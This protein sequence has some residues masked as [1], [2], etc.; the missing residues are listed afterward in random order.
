MKEKLFCGSKKYYINSAITIVLMFGFRFLPPIGT[1]SQVGMGVL[2]VFLGAI[3]GW[4][5]VGIFW[6]SALSIIALSFTGYGKFSELISTGMGS[7]T[8]IVLVTMFGLLAI[9]NESG[10]SMYLAKKIIGLKIGRGRP[11]VVVYLLMTACSL[12]FGVTGAFPIALMIWEIFYDMVDYNGIQKGKFT[13]F[14]VTAVMFGAI[15]G[16][17]IFPFTVVILV[18]FNIFTST[19]G[20]AAPAFVSYVI[21]MLV[22]SQLCTIVFILAGKYL[23]RI[24]APKLE[25]KKDETLEKLDTYQKIVL[26]VA[27]AFVAVLVL[28]NILPSGWIFTQA[29]SGLGVSGVALVADIF[30]IAVRF[31]QGKTFQAYM[32]KSVGWDLLFMCM[33]IT[34]I[35]SALTSAD[36]G[37]SDWVCNLFIPVFSKLGPA[38]FLILIVVIPLILTNFLNNIVMGTLFIPIGFAIAGSLGLNQYLVVTLIIEATS[39]ALVTPAACTPAAVLH[40]NSEWVTSNQAA[41]YG[42]VAVAL[43]ALV[44]I[45][46]G[47]PLGML[48]Y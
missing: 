41:K 6:P 38:V 22:I 39:M 18:L 11:W 12:L 34:L 44:I 27:A 42:A 45:A 15:L 7:N 4:S 3:Y 1:I 37:I 19:T 21:W 43:A 26:G 8:F 48:L 23:L 10:I 5:T 17:Q 16:G 35:S 13:Q 40:G 20:L 33:P 24:K 25:I 29:V 32:S 46:A 14:V 30:L 28:S 47:I 2:G 31:T 36:T 9:I